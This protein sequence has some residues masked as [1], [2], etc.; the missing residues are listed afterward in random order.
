M[1]TLA[2][3][4]ALG[5]G[6]AFALANNSVKSRHIAPGAVR[7]VDVRNNGLT[8][9]D[10]ALGC[11]AGMT[12]SGEI[13]HD[14]STRGPD[15]WAAAMLDCQ[16]EGKRLPDTAEGNFIFPVIPNTS[17]VWTGDYLGGTDANVI[18]KGPS[19]ALI[20]DNENN[21]AALGEYRCVITPQD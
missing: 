13:C 12:R 3:F 18:A 15:D 7:S 6:L 21:I 19:G 8:A 1:S 11:P 14:T 20:W 16:N 5:G 2:V 9:T 17:G 10:I 4:L